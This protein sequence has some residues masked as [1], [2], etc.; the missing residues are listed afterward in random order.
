MRAPPDAET[1]ISGTPA[2]AALSQAR[3]NF[4][5]V[6][7][8]IEPPMKEKS[9]TASSQD[10]SSIVAAPTTSASPSPVATSA[11]ASRSL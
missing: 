8:P 5:P 4:S 2:A 7:D 6:T 10:M 9:I 3:A 11:S 1:E